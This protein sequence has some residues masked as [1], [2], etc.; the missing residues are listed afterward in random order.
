MLHALKLIFD[1]PPKCALPNLVSI[2]LDHGVC[3]AT[4]EWVELG[5]GR[6][7]L[8]VLVELPPEGEKSA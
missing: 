6:W 3:I 4:E 5:A 7:S 8:K 2:D 1:G